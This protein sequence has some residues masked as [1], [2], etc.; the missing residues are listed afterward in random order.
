MPARDGTRIPGLLRS[1]QS[2]FDTGGIPRCLRAFFV[3]CFSS[4]VFLGLH[5]QLIEVPR[6]GV[7]LELQLPAYTTATATRD[8][9]RIC[10]PHHSSGQH[11]ILTPLS[12]ARD[13][14]HVLMDASRV[15]K[16]LSQDGN[17]SVVFLMCLCWPPSLLCL[18]SLLPSLGFPGSFPKLTTLLESFFFP[19][20]GG[21]TH[22]IWKFPG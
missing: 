7:Q 15:H 20:L 12:E 6:L 21:Y 16:P 8:P 18:I 1:C 9:S 22:G 14:T 11:W 2:C 10:D 4:F 13:R 17:P 5:Q 3:F 19:F